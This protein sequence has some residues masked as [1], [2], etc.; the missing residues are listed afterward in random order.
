MSTGNASGR[1]SG[2]AL[3]RALLPTVVAIA[4]AGAAGLLAGGCG[5]GGSSAGRGGEGGAIAASGSEGAGGAGGAGGAR[6]KPVRRGDGSEVDGNI[7]ASTGVG[8]G[9]GA[10]ARTSPSA[11]SA[12]SAASA[13]SAPSTPR[14]STR[15]TSASGASSRGDAVD[16]ANPVSVSRLRERALGVLEQGARSGTPQERVNAMEGL[17]PVPGRLAGVLGAA[18]RDENAGVRISAASLVG[19][20]KLGDLAEQTRGLLTEYGTNATV[21]DMARATAIFA[22]ARN[23]R[24]VDIGPLSS[25]VREHPDVAVRAQ[26]AGYL[27]QLG[28][29]SAAGLLR[30]AYMRVPSTASPA[31]VRIMQLQFAQALVQLGDENAINELRAA[32]YPATEQDLEV[33]AMAAQMIGEVGDRASQSQLIVLTA[34]KHP[35]TGRY[36]AEVRLACAW[37]LARL[38]NRNGSFVADEYANSPEAALRFQAA[39]VYGE[40]RRMTNLAALETMLDDPSSRVRIAAAAAVLKV[41]DDRGA[42]R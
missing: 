12:A 8:A 31:A 5:S 35:Q 14:G 11:T 42:G 22:L 37:S 26:V 3:R 1:V 19:R 24:E 6:W 36:P 10:A 15:E 33:T 39:S 41:T 29:A 38:G 17:I 7:A 9:V 4:S 23:G 40:T 27:G 34:W 30:D 16:V 18:L 32:L 2:R 28:N 13:A 21:R 25:L 20:L